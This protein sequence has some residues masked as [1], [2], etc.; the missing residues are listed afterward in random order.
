MRLQRP[1]GRG[2]LSRAGPTGGLARGAAALRTA[3]GAH[4][5]AKRDANR[6]RSSKRRG[7]ARTRT[8]TSLQRDEKTPHELDL[9][10]F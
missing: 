5:G 4:S 9:V 6:R 2:T 7:L 1:R 3:S 8:R 10:P